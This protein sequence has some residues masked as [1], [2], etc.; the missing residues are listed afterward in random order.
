MAVDHLS[1]A[2]AGVLAAAPV[3]WLTTLRA[4]GSPHVT[5]VWFVTEGTSIWF[6]SSQVN[7]KVRNI[8]QDPRVSVAIDG[9]GDDALVA[10]GLASVRALADAPEGVLDR[11]AAKYGWDPCDPALDGP[12]LAVEVAVTRWLL[13]R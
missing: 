12:R 5:P 13:G 3:A 1:A 2:S 4:D 10:E 11:L 7:V 8:E 6:A 9:T